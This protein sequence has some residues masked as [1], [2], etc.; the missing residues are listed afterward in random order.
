MSDEN[1]IRDP[2]AAML[3]TVRS[4]YS[5]ANRRRT[6]FQDSPPATDSGSTSATTPPGFTFRSASA[7]NAEAIPA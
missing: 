6:P 2:V 4:V 7:T 3:R 5:A 1:D